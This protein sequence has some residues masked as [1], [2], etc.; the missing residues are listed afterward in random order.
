MLMRKL[1]K[2]Q[3]TLHLLAPMPALPQALDG[4]TVLE[5]FGHLAWVVPIGAGVYHAQIRTILDRLELRGNRIRDHREGAAAYAMVILVISIGFALFFLR[6]VAP[7][8]AYLD[9]ITGKRMEPVEDLVPRGVGPG[10]GG[11]GDVA[12]DGHGQR[13][14]PTRAGALHPPERDELAHGLGEPRRHRADQK[15]HDREAR[16]PV[17][18]PHPPRHFGDDL[19][20]G[21]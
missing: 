12:D 18:Q 13:H 2:K 3:L 7:R 11:L 20:D 5:V 1:G 19:V 15:Q 6:S 10:A 4:A 9:R 17:R 8:E 14:E 21:P 16:Y